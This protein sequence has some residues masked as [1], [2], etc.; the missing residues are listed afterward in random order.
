MQDQHQED[1]E[2]A[3][4]DL[5]TFRDSQSLPSRGGTA[6]WA[7][8]ALEQQAHPAAPM[9]RSEVEFHHHRPPSPLPTSQAMEMVLDWDPLAQHHQ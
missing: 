9:Q 4:F 1:M 3:S 6:P 2:K 8:G 5:S 7:M